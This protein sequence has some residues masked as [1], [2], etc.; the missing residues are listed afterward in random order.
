[1]KKFNLNSVVTVLAVSL[2][3]CLTVP[4]S[5]LAA[6]PATVNLLTAGNFV[7][8]TKTGVTNTG[9]HTSFVTGNVGSSPITAA[10][11]DNIFCSEI[12]G[13][14]YG[15]DAAY[16][17][18]GATTCFAGNPGVPAVVPPDANKTLVD[19]AVLDMGTAY[20]NAEGRTLPDGINLGTAGEIG[21][22]TFAPGLWKW[23]T[24]VTISSNVT[25]SGSAS[26]VWIFQIAGDLDIAAG[27]SV[28]AGIKVLLAGGAQ[29]SNVFWQVG[30]VTGATL[31]TYSTFN[32]TI[33]TAKQVRIRTG[34][35]L[36]GRA[37]AQTQ[38]TLDANPV[39]I[40]VAAVAAAATGGTQRATINVV[41]T[42]VNDNGGTKTVLDF[43]LFV[44]GMSVISGVTNAFRAP[45]PAYAVTETG[46]ANYTR[47]FSGDCDSDGHLNL[48]PGDN[49]FCIVTN[50]DIG[51]PVIVAP[52]PPL[53]EVVKVPTPLALPSGPGPV[54]YTYT[55]RNI[56][57]VPVSTIT[58]VGDTCLPIILV[59]GDSNSDSKLDVNETWT[60]RCTTTL[61]E[62]HT[63]TVVATGWANGVSAV[64][65]ASATVVVGVP[66][67]PPLIHVTKV[68]S[69]LALP[70]GGGMVT[71]TKRVTN[72][73][74]VALSNVRLIDDKCASV[75]Y[76]YGDTNGD[77]KLD[78]TEAWIYTCRQ[79]LLKTTTNTVIASGEANGLIARDFAL[80]TV[81]VASALPALPNTGFPP[82]DRIFLWCL[83]TAVL[84]VF[85]VAFYAIRNKQ[86]V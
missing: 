40:P 20:T 68:P 63:S 41:K 77:S 8:L 66:V 85:S 1:M 2:L 51:A 12:S 27:G 84:S 32:G 54:T 18:S 65:I 37:L 82:G 5:A 61:T 47:V 43:P 24:G 14:I 80:V 62:T 64:D 46:D 67:V 7:I 76:V 25:L 16:T 29:A 48:N 70:A 75:K 23:N 10:A 31:G 78:T 59:S 17:G 9:S 13:V 58:M 86:S 73:G 74:A 81:V 38:V 50:N 26:D 4:A 30:G 21:G 49:K 36:N 45:A 44:N 53:I 6:G 39:T 42:V 19:I 60:Y 15:V 72:P 34:A 22:L 69:P 55:L 79:N 35:V 52:I 33:L 57:L 71:Y 11:M 3:F 28:P 83:I 56:G